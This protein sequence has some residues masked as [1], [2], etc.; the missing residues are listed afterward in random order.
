MDL[1]KLRTIRYL[2]QNFEK[3]RSAQIRASLENSLRKS[4]SLSRPYDHEIGFN[5][6]IFLKVAHVSKVYRKIE[7]VTVLIEHPLH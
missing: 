4:I 6:W 5:L 3:I 2:F 7:P 1:E